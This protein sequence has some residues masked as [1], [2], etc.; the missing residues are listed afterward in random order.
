MVSEQVGLSGQVVESTSYL[1]DSVVVVFLSIVAV[2]CKQRMARTNDAAMADALQ[3]MAQAVQNLPHVDVDVESKNLD[4]F[5]RNKPPVFLGTHNPDGAQA[6]LKKIEKIFRLMTC[7]D[8]QKV[9]LAHTCLRKKPK[10]G[11]I[12]LHNGLWRRERWLLG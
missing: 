1:C 6:W 7:S 3:A 12:T 5:Q 8:E 10:T 2:L 9:C 11:G 4:K